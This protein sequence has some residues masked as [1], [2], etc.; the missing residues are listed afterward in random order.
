LEPGSPAVYAA[1]VSSPIGS[2][3]VKPMCDLK[4][5]KD[6]E[7]V[8][9]FPHSWFYNETYSFPSSSWQIPYTTS[10]SEVQS[11]DL[12]RPK[13][14]GVQLV[15]VVELAVDFRLFNIVSLDP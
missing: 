9:T 15:S 1:L 14:T 7:N 3:G 11:F 10:D 5:C 6:V 12:S 2:T 13:N 4:Y 8:P